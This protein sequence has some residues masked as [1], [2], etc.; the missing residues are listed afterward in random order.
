MV[1][2]NEETIGGWPMAMLDELVS[3][4]QPPLTAEGILF[5]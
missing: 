5:R 2:K 3:K 4:A 1:M